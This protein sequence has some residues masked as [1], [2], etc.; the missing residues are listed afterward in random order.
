[1]EAP[2]HRAEALLD[3]VAHSADQAVQGFEHR[4]ERVPPRGL[5]L[6]EV[7]DPSLTQILSVGGAGITLVA[8]LASL[9]LAKLASLVFCE[10]PIGRGAGGGDVGFDDLGQLVHF[11]FVGRVDFDVLHIAV[12]GVGGGVATVAVVGLLA[13]LD[14]ARVRIGAGRHLWFLFAD[15]DGHARTGG[16]FDDG[17]VHNRARAALDFD[18]DGFELAVDAAKQPLIELGLHQPVAKATDGAGIGHLPGRGVEATEDHEVDAHLE[19]PLEFGIRQPVPLAQQHQL[20]H[21]Q[22]RVR[23]G[24]TAAGELAPV[25][26][27]ELRPDH[28]P[29]DELV[30]PVGRRVFDQGTR[31]QQEEALGGHGLAAAA[32]AVTRIGHHPA[33]AGHRGMYQLCNGLLLQIYNSPLHR[34]HNLFRLLERDVWTNRQTEHLIG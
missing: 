31:A 20:E 26:A 34:H 27:L 29:V 2:L 11:G 15:L 8:K 32:V 24:A 10:Q 21:R 14:P 22:R 25:Q 28:C 23:L 7:S 3:L 1:M 4:I 13:F 12:F 17:G 18:A 6:D 5:V 33:R 19:R 16:T 9:V 30:Q